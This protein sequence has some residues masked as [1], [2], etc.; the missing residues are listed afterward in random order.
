M[1]VAWPLVIGAC[2]TMGVIQLRVG[3]RRKP[4]A[5]HLLFALNALV[6]AVYAVCEMALA[7][8]DSPAQY[9]AWLRWLDIMAALQVVT[10]AAFVQVF[11]GT[12]RKWLAF[13]APG[14]SCVA[15][16]A[17]FM[18]EPKLVYLHLTGIK[19]IPTFGGA[20]YTDADGVENPLNAI[21][22]LGVFLLLVFV[23]DASITLWRRGAHRR[24]AVI[25]GTITFFVLTGGTQAALVDNEILRTPYLLS[26]A[27][28]AILVAMGWELSHDVLNAAQLASD[29]HEYEQRM[30]LTA[31]AASLGIWIR[32][33]VR[34]EIW[35]TDQWRTLLG[36]TQTEPI[37]FDGYLG[38][39]HPVDREVVRVAHA[40]AVGGEGGYDIEYRVS[41]PDAQVRWISSRGRVEF[42]AAGNPILLRGVSLD[43]TKRR[44][45]EQEV[46][47]QRNAVAHLSRV[48]TLGEISGSLAH[49]LNQPLGAILANADAAELHLQSESPNLAELRSILADIRRDDLR[50]GEIIHGMRAFLR[51][52]ELEMQPLE[53][54][55]IADEAVKLVS[56]DAVTRHISIGLEIPPALPRIMG[57]RIHLQQVLVNLLVNGM[58]AMSTCPIPLR[59]I[60][61]RATQPDP[62][63]VEI[64]IS[65]AGVGIPPGNVSRVF[66]PFHTSKPGG[67]GLGLSI[68]RSI[69]EAHGG[70]ISVENNLDQGATV[71]F[72]LPVSR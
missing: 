55:R 68:C 56:A 15:L 60:L 28:L 31:D 9:L 52:R 59:R 58:D 32:D 41:L 25:G 53:L 8:A 48:T 10:L 17:D 40:K 11:F 1:T 38:R 57:D 22:Y 5:A 30:S 69:I 20:T 19:K 37:D 51:R 71:R 35:T 34:N 14:L 47:R 65:D 23:V 66:D 39:I 54:A 26:F 7:C 64:A 45:A 13:L 72:T 67:L 2:V 61:I 63:T 18:P 12:G 29:L 62:A 24:A 49:E 42:N 6:V 27:Y 70:T 33:L 43:I 16:I 50:A 21:F 44:L 46:V 36:F 3:L 4:G